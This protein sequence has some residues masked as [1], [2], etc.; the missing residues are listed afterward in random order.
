MDK[1]KMT[2]VR[3]NVRRLLEFFDERPECSRGHATAICAVCGEELGAGLI[4]HYF[5]E[6]RFEVSKPDWKATQGTSEGCRLDCW[7]KVTN[8]EGARLFQVE[9]KNWSAHAIGG[10]RL[11]IIK[12]GSEYAAE[13]KERWGTY[14]QDDAGIKR[15]ALQKVLVPMKP[16]QQ[17][18]SLKPEPLACVWDAIHPE[19]KLGEPFFS[20]P[21]PKQTQVFDHVCFFSMS[22]YLRSLGTEFIQLEMPRTTDRGKWLDE[23]FPLSGMR[24]RTTKLGALFR[25]IADFGVSRLGTS[26]R[27]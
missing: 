19:G 21:L 2:E 7:I 14:W 3:A 10:K 22:A 12:T 4:T 15:K 23:L 17:W 20:V 18:A 9:I 27:N 25:A 1:V 6:R 5:R 16:P 11:P 13:L 8:S 24:W 26:N